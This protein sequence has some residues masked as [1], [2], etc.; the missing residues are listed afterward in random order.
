MKEIL[1][2]KIRHFDKS[3]KNVDW[4]DQIRILTS[5]GTNEFDEVDYN[6]NLNQILK[7]LEELL[8]DVDNFYLKNDMHSMQMFFLENLTESIL[9]NGF[10][11]YLKIRWRLREDS[12][13]VFKLENDEV[14]AILEEIITSM[15][16]KRIH[17]SPNLVRKAISEK[18]EKEYN[19][20]T[21]LVVVKFF[22]YLIESFNESNQTYN[23]FAI[24]LNKETLLHK[25]IISIFFNKLQNYQA[26]IEKAFL[27]KKLSDLDYE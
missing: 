18:F 19:K 2:E 25:D 4:D 20:E 1:E 17:R 16:I 3:F 27:I 5:L 6:G 24:M 10:K 7:L 23:S 9:R 13:E 21:I 12:Q 22:K 11:N 26:E 14:E 8:I 15:L